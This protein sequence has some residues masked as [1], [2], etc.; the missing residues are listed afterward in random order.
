MQ[1]EEQNKIQRLK[2]KLPD[3]K[4]CF[5]FIGHYGA[6]KSSTISSFQSLRDGGISTIA[7]PGGAE[8][9]L[10]KEVSS[11]DML[12]GNVKLFDFPGFQKKGTIDESIAMRK[13]IEDKIKSKSE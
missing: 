10:T 8:E 13:L 3:D 4:G 11:T 5:W 12:G 1:E 2:A 7:I 6:G 9:T